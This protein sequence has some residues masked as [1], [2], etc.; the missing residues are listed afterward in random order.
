[1]IKSVTQDVGCVW[2]WVCL[3]WKRELG[4]VGGPYWCWQESYPMAGGDRSPVRVCGFRA[5]RVEAAGMEC[6][7]KN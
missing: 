3:V 6:S 4:R 5:V 7:G 2:N 1:M